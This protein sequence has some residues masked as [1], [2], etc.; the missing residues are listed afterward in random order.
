MNTNY[1]IRTRTLLNTLSPQK[2]SW[3][4]LIP[5]KQKIIPIRSNTAFVLLLL[6]LKY[7][8]HLRYSN[9]SCEMLVFY[10]WHLRCTNYTKHVVNP[11]FEKKKIKSRIYLLE[12]TIG[13]NP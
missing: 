3:V 8:T 10:W 12:R 5:Q 4:C 2:H 7:S 13:I 9:L 6:F 11:F 1:L